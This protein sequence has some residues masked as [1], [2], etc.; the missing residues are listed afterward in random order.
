MKWLW[1]PALLLVFFVGDRVAAYALSKVTADSEFRYSRLYSGRAEADILLVGNSR[2]LTYYQPTIEELTGKSSFNLSYNGLPVQVADALAADYLERYGAP[3][4]MLAD[5][6]MLD[7]DNAALVQDF[8]VYAPY[9]ERLDGLL[10]DSFP[11]IWG[12]TRLAH[13]SRYGGEVAQRMF[14]YAARTDETWLLDRVMSESIAEAAADFE[15]LDNGYTPARIALFAQMVRRF[16]EA[17]TEVHLTINPYYPA[18]AKTVGK[19]DQL[20]ADVTAATGLEVRDYATAIEGREYFGDYQHLNVAG[21]Q[22]FLAR[23]VED[24]GL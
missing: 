4:I 15:P 3:E 16:Q 18:Y 10:R 6:T 1:I 21:A 7:L 12:G 20:A 24:L 2:G 23:L 5:V 14:Y 22:V 17:G 13:L 8:R 9:S 11:N 19:L